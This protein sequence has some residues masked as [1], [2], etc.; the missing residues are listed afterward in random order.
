MHL[1][2][3]NALQWACAGFIAVALVAL[4]QWRIQAWQA[5]YGAYPDEPSHFVGG[6]L[7][8]DYLTGGWPSS[9]LRFARNYYLHRPFFAIGYWPPVF[10]VVEGVWMGLFGHTRGS[11]MVY[12]GAIAVAVALLL[13]AVVRKSAGF[14]WGLVALPAL[15]LIP[16][17]Q[18]SSS[19]VMTDLAVT[20]T[21]LAATLAIGRYF[22]TPTG[23]WALA[24]GLLVSLAM[25]TKYLSAFTLI[26]PVLLLVIDRR[27]DLLMNKV[28]WIIPATVAVCCGPYLL[29]NKVTWIIPA[30]VAVCC[31]PWMWW[32]RQVMT[33][34]VLGFIRGTLSERTWLF[35]DALRSDIG[36]PFSALAAA[37]SLWAYFRWRKLSV[38]ERLLSLQFPCLATFLILVG[39]GIEARYL[40]PAYPALVA[41]IVLAAKSIKLPRITAPV[42]AA[43][44]V[45]CGLMQRAP[46]TLPSGLVRQAARD[47][48]AQ[49]REDRSA[50]LVPTALEGP[51]I[52]ELS[53][54]EPAR[55]QRILV[56]PS[57]LF[58]RQT[59]LGGNYELLTPNLDALVSIFD[60][61][62]LDT[63]VLAQ[64]PDPVPP[65]DRL[66]R[67]MVTHDTHR[68]KLART[69]SGAQGLS[70]DIYTRQAAAATSS[71]ADLM[72][73][74]QTRV[75]P[76]L[77]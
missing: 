30:T 19:I 35:A 62:P 24:A 54:A 48:L 49:H 2:R 1:D 41:L 23:R 33:I 6:L 55:S 3:K 8:S 43:G 45:V 44:L 29:M 65:H 72:N 21:C 42:F 39:P 4:S 32:S 12:V 36:I 67:E 40:I 38:S 10:Y 56:R 75:G 52:A 5:S 73:F 26:T 64:T 74:V 61:Y 47:W 77:K 68:W 22:S 25:M 18:W 46:H 16:S 57:K 15:L 13:F 27:W 20:L 28:T 69:Y 9:P 50:I 53:N 37:A 76:N 63:V 14:V 51:F 11:M 59:W 17:V 66:L 31:G 34:G 7:V 71:S 60:Q 70:V 58:S